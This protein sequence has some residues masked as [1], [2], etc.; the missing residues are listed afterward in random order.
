MDR[1]RM[2]FFYVVTVIVFPQA[3]IEEIHAAHIGVTIMK[4]LA[5]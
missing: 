4:R 2:A 3:V 1:L 5:Y